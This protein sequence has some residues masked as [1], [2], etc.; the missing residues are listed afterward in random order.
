[1][2]STTSLDP[3]RADTPRKPVRAPGQPVRRQRA[4][5]WKCPRCGTRKRLRGDRDG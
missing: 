2:T 3:S 1:M 5:A 4:P